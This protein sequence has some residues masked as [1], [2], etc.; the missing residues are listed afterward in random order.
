MIQVHIS[1]CTRIKSIQYKQIS[2]ELQIE[3]NRFGLEKTFVFEKKERLV[4][5]IFKQLNFKK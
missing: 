3:T 1:D 2:P 5:G 4:H